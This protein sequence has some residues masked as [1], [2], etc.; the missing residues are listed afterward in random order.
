[1]VPC[2]QSMTTCREH[3]I[4]NGGRGWVAEMPRRSSSEIFH[5]VKN[6]ASM[7][8]LMRAFRDVRTA[9]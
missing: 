6:L 3:V 8:S 1:V 9:D 7:R 5:G 2:G 4:L